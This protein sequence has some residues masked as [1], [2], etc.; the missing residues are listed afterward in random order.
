MSFFDNETV[1]APRSRE[2]IYAR[3]ALALAAAGRSL[4]IAVSLDRLA[5]TLRE[6]GP[7]A[8][9]LADERVAVAQVESRQCHR[10]HRIPLEARVRGMRTPVRS[11]RSR[12]VGTK[13]AA[14]PAPSRRW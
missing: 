3:A 7:E 8:L 4:E 9:V 11:H 10:E 14:R 2:H 1:M 12:G 5:P 13:S 6:H